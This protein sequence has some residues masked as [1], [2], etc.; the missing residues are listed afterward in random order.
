LCGDFD[1]QLQMKEQ[2]T[3]QEATVARRRRLPRCIRGDRTLTPFAAA[4]ALGLALLHNSGVGPLSSL[5]KGAGTSLSL[6]TGSG[7]GSSGGDG[8]GDAY[9][10]HLTLPMGNVAMIT[11]YRLLMLSAPE[12]AV[13]ESEVLSGRRLQVS[14]GSPVPLLTPC[15]SLGPP[16]ASLGPSGSSPGSPWV[17]FGYLWALLAWV[18][19]ASPWVLWVTL[20]L[21]ASSWVF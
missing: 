2:I 21:L 13:L 11:N 10:T 18:L 9:E 5:L 12:F 8:V 6:N 16:C 15:V 19:L 3:G 20:G 17:S 4:P 1:W 7:D 14:F